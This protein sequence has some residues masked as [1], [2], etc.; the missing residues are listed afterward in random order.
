M[1]RASE[2]ERSFLISARELILNDEPTPPP[3][4]APQPLSFAANQLRKFRSSKPLLEQMRTHSRLLQYVGAA[5]IV[6]AM[7]L[8]WWSLTRTRIYEERGVD[9]GSI[10]QAEANTKDMTPEENAEYIVRRAHSIDRGV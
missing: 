8:S 7:P 9:L 1:Q 4:P 6:L 3:A 5:L 2:T 10:A